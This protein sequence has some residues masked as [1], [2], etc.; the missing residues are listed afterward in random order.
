[1]GARGPAPKPTA[2]KE[3]EGNPGKRP[4][5][6]REPKPPPGLPVEPS[7]LTEREIELWRIRV[8][9]LA[10]VPNL[11]TIVDGAALRIAVGLEAAYLENEAELAKSGQLYKE[12]SGRIV[13]SPRL[14]LKQE[15][16]Q[17]LL[18]YYR[19]FGWTPSARSRIQLPADN[20][21]QS[22]LLEMVKRKAS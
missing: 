14:K 2:L 7:D 3:L 17:Q 16:A 5:N 10:Q 4:L 6:R 15:L 20:K 19:E 1:M 13:I 18:L 12:P 9:E 8:S 11:I 22:K 21:P